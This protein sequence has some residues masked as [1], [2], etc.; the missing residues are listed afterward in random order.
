MKEEDVSYFQKIYAHGMG[1]DY[2]I[3][4]TTSPMSAPVDDIVTIGHLSSVD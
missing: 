2:L 3:G 4:Y 1:Y